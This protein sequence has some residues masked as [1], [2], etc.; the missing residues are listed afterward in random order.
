MG[1]AINYD[2]FCCSEETAPSTEEVG[3]VEDLNFN[4]FVFHP[5]RTFSIIPKSVRVN[6]GKIRNSQIFLRNHQLNYISFFKN[7]TRIC[8][9]PHDN[10]RERTMVGLE[11]FVGK[12]RTK[13][14]LCPFLV[15]LTV[16]PL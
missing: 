10:A 8:R 9:G 4:R 2:R 7:S 13:M 6:E 5:M 11:T 3:F 1:G 14:V 15:Q 12:F 16:F